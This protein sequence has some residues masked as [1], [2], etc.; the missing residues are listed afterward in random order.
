MSASLPGQRNDAANASF[1]APVRLGT[2]PGKIAA[3]AS[4]LVR[5]RRRAGV[6]WTHNDSGGAAEVIAVR[7]DGTFRRRVAVPGASNVDWEDLAIDDKGRLVVGDLGDNFAE[8]DEHALYRFAEPDPEGCEPV[9]CVE[10]FRYRAPAGCERVDA[11]ALWVAGDFAFVVTK[12]KRLARLLRIALTGSGEAS[13]PPV[14]AELLGA[15]DG[16]QLVTG[17]AASDD[18]R[19]V[20]LLTYQG[21]VVLDLDG[22]L[23][24]AQPAAELFASL[25]QAPRREQAMLLG[26]AEG[27]VFDGDDLVVATEKGPF[28]WGQPLLWRLAPK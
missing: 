27:I 19:H 26:Q 16:L 6:F 21:I 3:E 24:P 17:A 20:A 10:V 8:R 2:L 22:P 14:V 12:E 5:S 25:Q 13:A 28:R 1:R 7:A 15:L 9:A 18:G 11:E 4:G 23:Q